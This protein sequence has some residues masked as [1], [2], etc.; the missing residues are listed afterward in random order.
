MFLYYLIKQNI[1]IKIKN[2]I[3][4]KKKLTIHPHQGFRSAIALVIL[5]LNKKCIKKK[6]R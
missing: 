2:Q 3:Y 1:K 5:Y 6:K 4:K